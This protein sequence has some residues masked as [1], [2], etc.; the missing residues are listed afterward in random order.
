VTGY[1]NAAHRSFRSEQDALL[2]LHEASDLQIVGASGDDASYRQT[3]TAEQRLKALNLKATSDSSFI[4]LD[5]NVVTAVFNSPLRTNAP[6]W[7][8]TDQN[9]E[10]ENAN[11]NKTGITTNEALPT[12]QRTLNC[13]DE[14]ETCQTP[15]SKNKTIA[16]GPQDSTALPV[17]DSTSPR[18]GGYTFFSDG[19]DHEVFQAEELNGYHQAAF[20]DLF[21]NKQIKSQLLIKRKK[22]S[23]MES[24]GDEGKWM[25]FDSGASRTVINADSPL[26]PLLKQVTPESG[27]CTVGSGDQ[28]P[29]VESGVLS[30][31][32]HATVVQGLKFDLYSGI[33]AAKRGISAVI[34]YDME[35]GD[36]QSFTFCKATGEITPLVE[37][38]LGVLELPLHLILSRADTTGLMTLEHSLT[39]QIS[40]ECTR[41]DDHNPA[42][43]HQSLKPFEI[44]AFWRALDSAQ[45][46]LV[47]R[48]L[49]SSQLSL[50]TFDIVHKLP[51]KERDFL[52]H[53]RLAHLPSKQILQL[54]KSGNKGLPFSGKF[55]E[56]CRPCLEGRHKAHSHGKTTDRHPDGLIGE[57]L[58]SDLAIV[59]TPDSN[60]NI[61]VLTVVD[62]IS[63]EVV[64]TLLKDK[65]AETVLE[66]CKRS[67]DIITTRSKSTLRTWQFDR[68]SEFCNHL[69]DDYIHR[70]LGAKQLFS[71]V[72]HPWENGR[73]ERSFQ[74]LF[75]KARSM[76]HYADLPLHYWGKAILHAAYLKNR[77]PSSRV[78]GLSPLQFRTGTPQ[79]YSKLRVFGCPAQIYIRP[80]NRS[81]PKL[82]IRSEHGTLIGMSTKGNGFIFHVN[83]NG[84]TAEV[85]SKDVLFNETFSD[86]RDTR[87]KIIR[88]GRTL[89]P[90][91][92]Q[93]NDDQY[94]YQDGIIANP[95]KLKQVTISNRYS[96]LADP[97]TTSTATPKAPVLT[98]SATT[99]KTTTITHVAPLPS[100]TPISKKHWH[101]VPHIKD[102]TRGDRNN[103]GP[104]NVSFFEPAS[105]GPATRSSRSNPGPSSALLATPPNSYN[106]ELDILMSC[107]ESKVPPS[108]C[109]LST[110]RTTALHA[111]FPSDLDGPDPKSQKEIDLLPP[112][113]AKRFNDATLNEFLGM[114]A[115]QVMEL[116]PASSFPP[117]T[118][119]YPAVVNWTTKKVLGVYSKTKCRICF[120]G[121]RYNKTYTDCFAPTVNF[122][123]VMII[124]CLAAMLGWFLGSL[125]YSQA[126]L[127]ADIDEFCVMRAPEFLREYDQSG[128]ELFWKLKKVIYGHPKGSRLWADCLHKKLTEL[129]FKQFMTDQCVYGKWDQWNKHSV[130]SSSTVTI[131]LVH[132]DDLIIATNNSSNLAKV[133]K[134]LLHAFDGIDQGDLKS[135][136]GVEIDIKPESI[137]LSMDYYWNKLMKKFNIS[138]KETESTPINA[139]VKRSDCPSV[140]DKERQHEYLQIIGSIIYGFTHC[141]LDLA[142]PVGML[143][144]VMHSPSVLH[145]KQLKHLL[146]YIN[147][148]KSSRMTYHRDHS[149]HY[150]MDFTF[151]CGVDSS[152]ADDE[153]TA[154]ST[155]GWFVLLR[156]GQGSVCAKSGQTADVALSSTESETIWAC[157]V[158]TQ[159]AYIKQFLDETD[160]FN[161]VT[162]DI[163]EDSQ[164]AINAQKKNVSQS[165]FRHIKVKYHYLRQLLYEGWAKMVKIHT[166]NQ[167][168]DL[169]T[170]ILSSSV[171]QKFTGIILGK[172]P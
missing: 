100:A 8:P 97:A 102:H 1:S 137:S 104:K 112:D 152:H 63:D 171:V 88:Q 53:A 42:S 44:S 43:T 34:D 64:I 113:K 169:A 72:E 172:P 148:T 133:K 157:S 52:I 41:A 128:K 9:K 120:G 12:N 127:N 122:T 78:Q 167:F 139:K 81:H 126:Y 153:D 123:S 77:S 31:N 37:R 5:T 83:R 16:S 79:D 76:L 115:K 69:F 7:R 134:T 70:Q 29:Y 84:T 108:L 27:S 146:R 99:S 65:T 30:K 131:I 58:H 96:A 160:L 161:Q 25:Y 150:G 39:S 60:G 155:G 13:Y 67:H 98:D 47:Q 159:G 151:L 144:R 165:R 54:I 110:A 51:Q 24:E 45:T 3:T 114:K 28:L 143:T 2:Y 130:N 48:D 85:D 101:Y 6:A 75:S 106:P 89:D 80:S 125:D 105:S 141:R 124:L 32:N 166:S 33:S 66:A 116:I 158:A 170:K 82:G 93:D 4:L 90:D 109:L 23:M 117:G 121:H 91:L 132:S 10:N 56:L 38:R 50:F 20:N 149:V 156:Q 57:H 15:S 92:R 59:N 49:N 142:F 35:T 74:T 14:S 73:A 61:Y 11:E 22:L 163:L 119:I 103:D 95:P 62:E 26:R 118:K 87:G 46:N 140:P 145:L 36:N 68:G 129:G 135:F 19:S 21:A 94:D 17:L 138:E 55:V 162:F 136:C 107:L 164:P 168:A 147:G 86:I 154:R 71:N 111:T 40:G 18:N